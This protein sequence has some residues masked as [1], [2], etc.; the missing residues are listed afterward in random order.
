MLKFDKY[1]TDE[2]IIK[3]LCRTRAKHARLRNKKHLLHVLTEKDGFNYHINT[4]KNK[5]KLSPLEKELSPILPP[6]RKWKKLTK[7]N[8]YNER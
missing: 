4:D 2:E 3:Y 6:R 1:F 5:E 8:R 7:I